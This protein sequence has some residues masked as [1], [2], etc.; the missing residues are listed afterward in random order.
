MFQQLNSEFQQARDLISPM[1]NQKTLDTISH[2]HANL[3]SNTAT[4]PLSN[5]LIGC[6]TVD[7]EFERLRRMKSIHQPQNNDDL[8]EMYQ[9]VCGAVKAIASNRV[10]FGE[11]FMHLLEPMYDFV[12]AY[13]NRIIAT[14]NWD[15]SK[16]SLLKWILGETEI[17]VYT[18]TISVLNGEAQNLNK[19]DKASDKPYLQSSNDAWTDTWR[20][21]IEGG[22]GIKITDSR[23]V[24]SMMLGNVLNSLLLFD[25]QH[26]PTKHR[27]VRWNAAKMKNFFTKKKAD[28]PTDAT[29]Q[30]KGASKR[31]A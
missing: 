7:G 13:N 28:E 22:S 27:T 1:I 18:V 10:V 24:K 4:T 25:Q 6:H 5:V 15:S 31:G 2:V 8:D 17:T 9:N 12:G 20:S 30:N 3:Q 23:L 29:N 14:R 26:L 21:I 19:S 16:S 11:A